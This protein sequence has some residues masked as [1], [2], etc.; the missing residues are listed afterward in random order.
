MIQKIKIK[1]LLSMLGEVVFFELSL[2]L[3][4]FL[5]LMI[6]HNL[7][8]N[9]FQYVWAENNGEEKGEV[10]IGELVADQKSPV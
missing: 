7:P 5:V 3:V 4:K 9:F 8:L 2:G 1:N 10:F 6:S